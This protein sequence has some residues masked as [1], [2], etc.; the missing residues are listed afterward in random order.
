MTAE[1]FFQAHKDVTE[2][3][4]E[5]ALKEQLDFRDSMK[6]YEEV[7]ADELVAGTHVMS[8]RWVDTMNTPTVRRSKHTAKVYEDTHNESVVA[9]PQ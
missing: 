7:C 9:Q 4:K 8:G 5:Q 3:I 6:V 1:S 2:T